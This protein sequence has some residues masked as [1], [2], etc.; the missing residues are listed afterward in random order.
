M[1]LK[2]EYKKT[3][4]YFKIKSSY[5][6]PAK[7]KFNF[8]GFIGDRLKTNEEEWLLKA[9]NANPAMIEIFHQRDLRPALNL[10][11]WSGEYLGKFLTGAVL[12]WKLSHSSSL[13]DIIVRLIKKLSEIQDNNVYVGPFPKKNRFFEKTR[14]FIKSD[15]MNLMASNAF[16]DS[17]FNTQ[18]LFKKLNKTP[19]YERKV[20]D[21]YEFSKI[22][23]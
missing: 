9:L 21:L 18:I 20:C 13:K 4:T 2:E 17:L 8:N 6:K 22:H 10:D 5:K 16:T 15:W 3:N 14:K 7:A 19:L 12:C 11:D 1:S 23:Y